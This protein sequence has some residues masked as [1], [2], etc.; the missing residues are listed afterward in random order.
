MARSRRSSGLNVPPPKRAE[1]QL[2]R[3]YR[4]IGRR[5]LQLLSAEVL[6]AVAEGNAPRVAEELKNVQG[7][8]DREFDDSW[9]REEAEKSGRRVNR[10]NA[11]LFYGALAAKARIRIVGAPDSPI[12]PGRVLGTRGPRLI[13]QLNFQ[14][15]ILIDG[16]VD[17]NIR[18][19]STLRA[20]ITEAVGD[21]IAAASVLGTTTGTV[22]GEALVSFSQPEIAERLLA[23]WRKNGVPSRIPTRR[24][25]KNGKP[26]TITLENHANLIARD[27]ISKLNGQLNKTRQTSAGISKFVW[28]TQQD[29]RVRDEHEALAGKTFG[30][31]E[32]AGGLIPGEPINCRCWG[33]AVI[34]RDQIIADGNWIQ[35]GDDEIEGFSERSRRGARQVDP[36]PGASIEADPSLKGVRFREVG[37]AADPY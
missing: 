11:A 32:G 5:T 22:T 28:R 26:A 18:Y 21:Q 2:M 16:F 7:A 6:P 37:G 3:T 33:E 34:D 10:T 12:P 24:I 27:Q 35:I 30:W 13:A 31:E 29:D 36:G 19:I 23:Q 9:V 17:Q 25:K 1:D 14:P 15:Q 8:I 20:G 4:R